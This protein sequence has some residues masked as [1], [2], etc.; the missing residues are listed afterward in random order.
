MSFSSRVKEELCRIEH[1][2]PCCEKAELAALIHGG[3]SVNLSKNGLSLSIKADN[4]AIARR[5]F[6]MLQ[7]SFGVSPVLSSH[8]NTSL[9]SGKGYRV[10]VDEADGL[11]HIL[12]ET[13]YL[14]AEEEGGIRINNKVP[15]ALLRKNCCKYAYLRGAFLASGYVGDP[16]KAYHV[17]F[18]LS[19][20]GY[21]ANF[22]SWLSRLLPGAKQIMRKDTAIIYIK[23]SDQIAE[24]L[25]M[26]GAHTA[27][28]NMESI[29]VTKDMRNRVNRIVN[30]EQA[31][32]EKTMDAAQRQ[33]DAIRTIERMGEFSRLSLP[34]RQTAEIRME[35]PELPLKEL[36]E[37][38]TPPIGKSAVNHRLRKLVQIAQEL[39]P[40]ME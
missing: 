30:C 22:C 21:A 40:P 36:G 34:L 19:N 2:K 8:K 7:N 1:A 31:N 33:I 6:S 16:E 17:E 3:A 27:L 37:L 14:K 20:E 24:L 11:R 9:S 13:G 18:S 4:A 5:V 35:N 12:E 23:E 28:L 38:F 15:S 32:I 25:Q 10:R 39:K 26:M 29:R